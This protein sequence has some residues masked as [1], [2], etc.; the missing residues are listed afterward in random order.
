[1]MTVVIGWDFV[2]GR[3]RN[4]ERT[5]ESDGYSSKRRRPFR[6]GVVRDF[7]VESDDLRHVATPER[8]D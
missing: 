8:L 2:D 6:V 1:M 5:N 4:T 3:D 7:P